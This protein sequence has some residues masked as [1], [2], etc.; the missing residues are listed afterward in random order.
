MSFK[1]DFFWNPIWDQP[2]LNCMET[3]MLILSENTVEVQ[4]PPSFWTKHDKKLDF[5]QNNLIFHICYN[6]QPRL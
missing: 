1:Q 4:R 2:K 3:C 5:N 6:S